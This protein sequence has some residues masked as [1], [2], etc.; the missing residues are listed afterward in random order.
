MNN[1]ILAI[2]LDQKEYR[3]N[4]LMLSVFCIEYGILTLVARGA[5]KMN[6]KLQAS[7]TP[8]IVGEYIIDYKDNQTMF[9]I[10]NAVLKM[11]NR[12]IR[13][14]LN[15]VYIAQ[16]FC[17]I[18]KTL[19][20]DSDI[21]MNYSI[22]E[23]LN[24]SLNVLNEAHFSWLCLSFYLAKTL[25]I[26]GLSP[27]VEACVLCND[28]KISCVSVSDG[29]FVC[30]SCKDHSSDIIKCSLETLKSFR[31]LNKAK[32]ENYDILRKYDDKNLYECT[33]ILMKFLQEHT[34]TKF[35]SFKAI[36]QIKNI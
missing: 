30:N 33:E 26:H 5:K 23:L 27:Y 24:F 3:E 32:I 29:G 36:E 20:I 35:K 16:L 6:S 12:H 31:L 8:F 14:N 15:K 11:S 4:D 28:S 19:G 18:V 2:V 1:T 17:E 21:Q 25:E 7:C 13:E 34:D 10:K 9:T 22:F